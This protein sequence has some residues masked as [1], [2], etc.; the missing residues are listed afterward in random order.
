ML[1][2]AHKHPESSP[3]AENIP[4]VFPF[5]GRTNVGFFKTP[6]ISAAREFH[7]KAH[8]CTQTTLDF[9]QVLLL[10]T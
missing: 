4:H 1:G 7:L 2:T 3:F 6:F 10:F 5:G 9:R 8:N